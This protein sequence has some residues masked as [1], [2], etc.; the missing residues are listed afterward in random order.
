M[1]LNDMIDFFRDAGMTVIV[2]D[3]DDPPAELPADP[4]PPVPMPP[5]VEE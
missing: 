1:T 4:L 2:W 5:I 3:E